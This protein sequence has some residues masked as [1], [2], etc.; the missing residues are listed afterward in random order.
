ML[1]LDP[2]L[3]YDVEKD[4]AADD[5]QT[6]KASII[7]IQTPYAFITIFPDF[8]KGKAMAALLNRGMV[9]AMEIEGFDDETINNSP[10]YGTLMPYSLENAEMFAVLLTQDLNLQHQKLLD[11]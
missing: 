11:E 2:S 3:D 6:Q 5:Q 1:E 7:D 4:Y 9:M 10:L 8:K